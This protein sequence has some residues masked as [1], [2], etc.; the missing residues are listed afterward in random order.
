VFKD[1]EEGVKVPIY[2]IESWKKNRDS[3][4]DYG[5][6]VLYDKEKCPC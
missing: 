5:V 1:K 2:V 6:E 4:S 3:N